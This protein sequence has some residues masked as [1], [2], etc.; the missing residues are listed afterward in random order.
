MTNLD[1]TNRKKSFVNFYKFADQYRQEHGGIFAFK[2]SKVVK[3]NNFKCCG[4]F[5]EET[6]RIA[7][8]TQHRLFEETF[9]H[10]FCHF[11]QFIEQCPEWV[12]ADDKFW[13]DLE[14]KNL[15][16]DS[17]DATK[18]IIAMERDCE[19]RALKMNKKYRMF[20]AKRY[21]QNANAYFYF[22]QYVFLNNCWPATGT[23]YDSRLPKM[24][25]D[26]ILPMSAFEKIDMNIM[27]EYHNYFKSV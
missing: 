7:A 5:D 11:M 1:L 21:A 6:M 20:N 3:V 26:K 18:A 10:E 27:Q 14:Q 17:W 15:T 19:I 23:L 22:Y 16:L 2:N 24:M 4:F 13:T 8:A 12:N 9:V 25:P